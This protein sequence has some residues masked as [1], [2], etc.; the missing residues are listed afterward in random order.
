MTKI[1]KVQKRNGATHISQEQRTG[2]DR[3][4][5]Y[6][7]DTSVTSAPQWVVQSRCKHWDEA[8]GL[9]KRWEFEKGGVFGSEGEAIAFATYAAS[10]D[11]NK[12]M[13]VYKMRDRRHYC[14]ERGGRFCGEWECGAKIPAEHNGL[15]VSKY[16]RRTSAERREQ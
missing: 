14:T 13:R 1:T 6:R 15:K 5:R 4:C 16:E 11:A 2:K 12:I 8:H 7:R 10:R 3:R 9:Q